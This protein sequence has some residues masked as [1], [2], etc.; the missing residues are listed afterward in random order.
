M[1]FFAAGSPF[2]G[3][4]WTPRLARGGQTGVGPPF[5]GAEKASLAAR[6]SPRFKRGVHL[7]IRPQARTLNVQPTLDGK[8]WTPRLK[9]GESVR[10]ES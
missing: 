1:Y 7:L 3:K 5:D 10:V 9:R 6:D 2:A 4:E 8:S